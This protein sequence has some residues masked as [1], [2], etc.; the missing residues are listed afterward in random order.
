MEPFDIEAHAPSLY[1][2]ATAPGVEARY[3]YLPGEVPKD[4]DDFV[5]WMKCMI[6][7]PNVYF[8]VIDKR[9]N[10]AEGRLA[11]ISIDAPNGAA[12]FGDVQWGPALQRSRAATEAFYL[13]SNYLFSLGYRRYVWRCNELNLPSKRAAERF[14]FQYEGRFRQHL[15]LK[16]ANRNTLWF[17]ILDSEWPR[18]RDGFERWLSPDNFD[19]DGQQ[20]KKLE[21]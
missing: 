15:V 12:E 14:G 13:V 16:G 9:T 18:I 2:A 5:E 11:L 21:F 19:A 6:A 1:K 4:Y 10:Q 17:S 7:S 3:Q 8:S 20:I